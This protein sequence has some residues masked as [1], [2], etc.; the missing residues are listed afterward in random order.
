MSSS[1]P[2]IGGLFGAGSS[3]NQYNQDMGQA[4]TITGLETG[5]YQSMMNDINGILNGTGPNGGLLGS[6]ENANLFPSAGTSA[7]KTMMSRVGS[8]ANPGAVV[9]NTASQIGQEGMAGQIQGKQA[10]MGDISSLLGIGSGLTGSLSSLVNPYMNAASGAGQGVGQGIGGALN[11][12]A[13]K[14]GGSGTGAAASQAGKL[15]SQGAKAGA[16]GGAKA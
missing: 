1:I 8:I 5:G 2:I 12:A 13:S 9:E 11:G 4:N 6:L 7:M 14:M 3:A 16:A 10:A 15:G